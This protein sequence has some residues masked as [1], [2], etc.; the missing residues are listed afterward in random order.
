M[1]SI[2]LV[3]FYHYYNFCPKCWQYQNTST[4]NLTYL[5]SRVEG[6]PSDQ[7]RGHKWGRFAFAFGKFSVTRGTQTHFSFISSPSPVL[8]GLHHISLMWGPSANGKSKELIAILQINLQH[9]LCT[10]CQGQMPDAFVS[11]ATQLF[12]FHFIFIFF[13]V[14]GLRKSISIRAMPIPVLI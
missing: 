6:G 1:V 3:L 13:N 12:F 2:T 10:N 9:S 11:D 7:V 4:Y 5:A 14:K 8:C